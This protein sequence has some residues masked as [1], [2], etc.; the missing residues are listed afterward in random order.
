MARQVGQ[1]EDLRRDEPGD[2]A[3]RHVVQ[4]GGDQRQRPVAREAEREPRVAEDLQRL[5]ERRR[6]EAERLALR[7]TLVG[8]EVARLALGAPGAGVGAAELGAA[9]AEAAAVRA[10]RG[11]RLS[12]RRRRVRGV[13]QH[14]VG[15]EPQAPGLDARRRPRVLGDP[16][17]RDLVHPGRR[18]HGLL[19]PDAQHRLV[20]DA[21]VH[22]LQPVVP[23]AQRLL[24]EADRRAR[25]DVVRERV[26]P[27]ADQPLARPGQALEQAQDAVGV[28]VGPAADGVDGDLDGG[29]VLA[30][31][32]VLPVGV[33]ALVREPG[34]DPRLVGLEALLPELAPALA[35]GGLVRRLALPVQHAGAP[36]QQVGGQHAAALVVHVVGVA[37]VGAHERDDRL[38]RRR[39]AGGQLQAVEAAPRD[40]GHADAAG[41]PRLGGDPGDD[42]EEVLLLLRVVLVLRTPSD[43]PLPRRSTRTQA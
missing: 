4:P 17:P 29:V 28:A 27:R 7:R 37:V 14:A 11:G 19:H 13:A 25:R 38:Q 32:A 36:V 18:R 39:A 2:A 24:Q 35:D 30:D 42:L 3:R 10:V 26:R 16:A 20:H 23:P 8:G 43:S 1:V 40:A 22:A 34:V 5:R 12:I 6:G 31:R 9:D 33:A 41:A 15:V 21:G